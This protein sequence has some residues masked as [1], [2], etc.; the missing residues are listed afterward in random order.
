[1]ILRAINQECDP[2]RIGHPAL[3]QVTAAVQR[4]DRLD[5]H[6]ARSARRAVGPCGFDKPQCGTRLEC[7]GVCTFECGQKYFE[8]A[9]GSYEYGLDQSTV[10]RCTALGGTCERYAP[11]VHINVC[12]FPRGPGTSP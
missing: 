8:Q 10:D 1:M 7:F 11:E 4:V 6:A 3:E 12:K 2:H 5:R 9:D